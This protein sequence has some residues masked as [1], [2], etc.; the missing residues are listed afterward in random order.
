MVI[1]SQAGRKSGRTGGGKQKGA[2]PVLEAERK[3]KPAPGT[4]GPVSFPSG[5]TVKD[6]ADLLEVPASEII[7][8]MMKL[9]EMVTI[10][11]SLPDDVVLIL[12]E[13]LERQ[14][15]L[16]RAEDDTVEP[17]IIDDPADLRERGPV[18]TIMGH[19]DHGKTSL[20]DAVRETEVAKSEAG[21]ITQH[22]GAY[23]VHHNDRLVTFIDTPGHEAFTAMR[24][25]GAKVTDVAVIVVAAND[26]VM[27][28]T[29]EAID[30]AKAAEVP[31]VVAVNK[32]D[33][34]DANPDRV[35]QQLSEQGLVPSEWGGDTEMVEV[36][37][38]QRLNLENLVDLILLVA[39]IQELKA[40]PERA[41][42][43][44]RGRGPAG[45]GPRPRGYRVDPARHA[46]AWATPSRAA[47]PSGGSRRCSTSRGPP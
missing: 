18:V 27:P 37:A 28:Q 20:L 32:M 30:H 38:K 42:I 6:L 23:Q 2:A 7:K 25:R 5:A 16:T 1:D 26:G 35:K 9:G 34:P 12:A 29:I 3:L 13:E 22:I 15:E 39:D 19:V 17:E 45:C 10:T 11:Q 14:V 36:S 24:A 47:R 21:G 33:L 40:N 46:C 4:E 44:R 31:M 43:R 8:T 41:G